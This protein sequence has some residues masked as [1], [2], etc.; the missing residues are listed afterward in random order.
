MDSQGN[1]FPTDRV[2]GPE[3]PLCAHPLPLDPLDIVR[4][5]CCGQTI[6]A[7]CMY[8]AKTKMVGANFD[9]CPYCL[10]PAGTRKTILK[11]LN[12]RVNKHKDPTAMFQLAKMYGQGACGIPKNPKKKVEL[13]RMAADL[14]GPEALVSLSVYYV[15][16][17]QD[18]NIAKDLA[19]AKKYLEIAAY[20]LG[21]ALAW[22]NLGRLYLTK[23][24]NIPASLHH[25]R[26][27]ASYGYDEALGNVKQGYK[28]GCISKEVFAATLRAWQAANDDMRTEG[29]E[30]AKAMRKSKQWIY[31]E[32][33]NQGF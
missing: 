30:K 3:C 25:Y 28:K 18:G 10:T 11:Q 2:P 14:E 21:V 1:P 29:R 24:R 20:R 26:V 8:A 33:M 19:K 5:F 31:S 7:G 6:C 13:L 15:D 4:M 16:G 12:K 23:E 27:A 17:Y 9:K 22:L 32:E